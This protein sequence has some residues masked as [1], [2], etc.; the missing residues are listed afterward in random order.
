MTTVTHRF[1]TDAFIQHLQQQLDSQRYTIQTEKKL[2][3]LER[4]P[5]IAIR[6]LESGQTYVIELVHTHKDVKYM[7]EV[8]EQYQDAGIID[9]WIFWG[10]DE[11]KTKTD[12]IPD[13]QGLLLP[14]VFEGPSFV[15][16]TQPMRTVMDFSTLYPKHLY[17]FTDNLFGITLADD[18]PIESSLALIGF[19]VYVFHEEIQ[20]GAN[21]CVQ[22]AV[23]WA[24]MNLTL[25][26]SIQ[27]TQEEIM[28]ETMLSGALNRLGV[29]EHTS[30]QE[31]SD[32]FANSANIIT[33]LSA[34]LLASLENLTVEQQQALITEVNILKT[35]DFPKMGQHSKLGTAEE[36][37]NLLQFMEDHHLPLLKSWFESILPNISPELIEGKMDW[38]GEHPFFDVNDTDNGIIKNPIS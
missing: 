28:D 24:T 30:A 9:L 21:P 15:T 8:H 32:L 14:Q 23:Q 17:F 36:L 1:M 18:V 37:Q 25:N 11:P 6:D 33:L 19:S 20:D 27:I 22:M 2:A 38:M 3:P 35:L 12:P 7:R 13:R 31:A 26:D 34:G 5:D 16:L 10:E 4:R 29:T